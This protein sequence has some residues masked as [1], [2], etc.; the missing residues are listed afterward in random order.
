MARQ[1]KENQTTEQKPEPQ[2]PAAADPATPKRSAGPKR[3]PK[4]GAVLP[5]VY[6]TANGLVRR[7][8]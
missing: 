4:T 3:D 6:R 8:N 7:D 2:A 1:K 5:S